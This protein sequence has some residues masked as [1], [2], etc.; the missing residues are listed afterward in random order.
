M[1]TMPARGITVIVY[2]KE[3]S[4][5][6]GEGDDEVAANGDANEDVQKAPFDVDRTPYY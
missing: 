6:S 1:A 2:G 3:A 5:A 4:T